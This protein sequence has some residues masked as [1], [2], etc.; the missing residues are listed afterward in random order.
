L[1]IIKAGILDTVQDHGRHGHQQLGI[2]PSGCMDRYASEVVNVLVGNDVNDAVIEM[3]FPAG[4]FLIEEETL[5][6]IGGADFSATINGEEISLWQPV[7]LSTNSILQFQKWKSGA[8]C[9]LAVK[10]KLAIP[11]WLN[12]YSTNLKAGCGGYHGRALR[13]DDVIG[14]FH[15]NNYKNYLNNKDHVSLH[16]KAD[17]FWS[18]VEDKIA[19]LPGNE[20]NWLTPESQE[21]F[22]Q[23]SFIISSSADRM[24]YKLN[25]KL[26]AK[27]N[28]E[29]VSSAVNFGTIQLLPN[30]ELIVLMADHQTTGGYPRVAHVIAAHLP[31]LAQMR[32]GETINFRMTDIKQA[33]QLAWQQKQHLHQL[34]NACNFRLKEF[35][36]AQH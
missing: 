34:Q 9:Y 23:Q 10:E 13:K 2:N 27:N 21:R 30:G 35:L 24:G 20:W 36:D 11:K 32:A 6:A 15:Q 25:G 19:V 5:I 18:A 8:R 33:E 26:V 31:K 28:D 12:S 4:T 1:K 16:W 3:H 17:V 14:L 29:L 7:I 22:N